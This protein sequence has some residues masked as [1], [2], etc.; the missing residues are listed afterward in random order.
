MENN[1]HKL[2]P[3]VATAAPFQVLEDRFRLTSFPS[4]PKPKQLND[5]RTALLCACPVGFVDN[6]AVQDDTLY[7]EQY[8]QRYH[9]VPTRNNSW[10]DLFNGLIWLQFPESKK[11]LNF[12][13]CQD[14]EQFGV[15]PRTARRNRMTHFDECGVVLAYCDTDIVDD[16][17]QHR[18]QSAFVEKRVHW[19]TR[20]EATIFGHANYEM[21]LQPYVGLTGKWLAVEVEKGYFSASVEEK[22]TILDRRLV[23]KFSTGKVFDLGGQLK[24][25]PLLGVPGWHDANLD[26]RFYD[27]RDYFRPKRLKHPET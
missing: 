16:L 7:Y 20:I 18:W 22:S 15:H 3:A 11:Y 23:D 14:I 17:A 9:E 21:M 2:W 8:I 12:L 27:N 6:D 5:I 10:H 13:H 4:F 26:K 19:G 24:P 1:W 25:L